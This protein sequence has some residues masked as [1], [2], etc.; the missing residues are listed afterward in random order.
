[1]QDPARQVAGAFM[2]WLLLAIFLASCGGRSAEWAGKW[3]QTNVSPPGTYVEMTLTGSGTNVGGSG[4]QHREAGMDLAFT[5]GGS[6]GTPAGRVNF[7]YPDGTSEGFN[8]SQLD[9]DHLTLSGAQ[10]TLNFTRQ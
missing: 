1:M 2:R 5:I 8:Y 7:N 10:R 9:S 4:V 6:I 3:T